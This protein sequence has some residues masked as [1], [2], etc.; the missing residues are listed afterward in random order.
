MNNV[1]LPPDAPLPQTHLVPVTESGALL[2]TIS[3]VAS[4]PN[5]DVSKLERLMAMHEKMEQRQAEIAFATDFAAMQLELKPIEERGA[6]RNKEGKK[7]STYSLWEDLNEAIKPTLA[8]FGFSLS[9]RTRNEGPMIVVVGVLR[10]RLGHSD[11]SEF[12]AAPDVSGSKNQIQANGSSIAYGKRYTASAL[13][14]LTSYGD[15]DDGRYGA[16]GV[17][18]EDQAEEIN[19]LLAERRT[20]LG[21][22]LMFAGAPS[23]DR[24][25]SKDYPRIIESLRAKA[26]G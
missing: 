26:Q 17:I 24:I 12:S 14:N 19:Q 3:Q 21:R 10:H 16:G 15:D 6:I 11:T 25:R 22:F 2:A 20:N 5:V 23:V 4:N 18:S 13:L 7:T 1:M 8:K 9:F